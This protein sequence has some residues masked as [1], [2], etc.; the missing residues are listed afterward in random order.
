MRGL[1]GTEL[2][3]RLTLAFLLLSPAAT[4]FAGAGQQG[5]AVQPA[6]SADEVVRRAVQLELN[7]TAHSTH[8]MYR[9]HKVTPDRDETRECLETAPGTLCRVIAYGNQPLT[10]DTAAKEQKRIEHLVND[11]DAWNSRQKQQKEDE[12]RVRKMVAAL[13]EA[14]RYQFDGEQ[15]GNGIRLRF[16]PNPDY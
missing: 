3:F 11:H 2:W 4:A 13:P 9:L 7:D 16:E 15:N 8:Y 14:F 6:L 5:Q 1:K 10:G 12:E